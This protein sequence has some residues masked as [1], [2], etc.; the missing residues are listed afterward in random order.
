MAVLLRSELQS[1]ITNRVSPRRITT[2][3]MSFILV[4]G[5]MALSSQAQDGNEPSGGSWAPLANAAPASSVGT[6]MLLT[7]GT[8]F[9]QSGNDFRHWLKLTPD[10]HGSYIKGTWTTLAPMNFARLYFASEVLQDGR[11]WV[12]GGEYT[13]PYLD[14]NWGP[15]GEIYNPVSNTWTPSEHYP[16]M[17]GF[18]FPIPVTSDVHLTTG[19]AVITG[20]YSTDRMLPGWTIQGQ[21]IPS[22]ATVVSVD[23]ATQVTMS[24]NATLTGPS[25]AVV[26]TGIPLAAFGDDPSTLISGHRILAGNLLNSSTYIYSVDSNSWAFAA[27]KVYSSESSDEEGWTTL[28][29]GPIL[30]YDLFQAVATGKGYAELYHPKQDIWTSISPADGSANGTLPVLSSPALGYELGPVL[31]L[32]DGRAI[33]IGANQ[34]TAL[35][36]Q[37]SNTWAAGPDIIGR[38]SNPYGTIEHAL[39]GADDASAALMPNGHVLL[40]AD[41]GPNPITTAGNTQSSSNIISHIPSTAGLQEFW[42][43]VQANGKSDVIPPFT[44]ITSIDSRHQIHIS[45]NATGS[46]TGLGLVLGGL[47]SNPTQLFDFDPR[48][49]RVSP[50]NP[51]LSDP[52]L[53]FIPAYVT[54]ML[55]LPNGQILFNDGA[56]SQLYAYTPKG[57]AN[58][59]YWPV[60][61]H[62][63]YSDDGV[64]TLTGRQLNGPSD[65]SAYGDDA[66]SNENYPIVR[67][68]NSKGEV[69]YC[70]ST[71]WTS[72]GVGDIP[73]EKVR[74]TLNPAVGPGVYQLTV[75]AGGIS[76]APVLLH[77]RDEEIH[78]D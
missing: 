53:P 75:S 25:K 55:V 61:E 38:L 58:P 73:R 48:E 33:V 59:A 56:G 70:R 18:P 39:F 19:S 35:Y 29:G 67:L 47:F 50:V 76:S 72:T 71:D 37:S 69:F 7:D 78:G 10:S 31:G 24:A 68:E 51:P 8:V 16:N 3:I 12:L 63:E 9:A 32:Q 22:G 30:T 52:N 77:I 6:M 15:S 5:G 1:S 46:T 28:R 62:V 36:T 26:F 66:Q 40:A 54:R 60:I 45:A 41:A 57:S 21:G 44:Y 17:A 34:H 4:C 42:S 2:Y 74:F 49:D 20:I 23:S 65:A 64:F 27:D 43:V 14:A 11:V 13:G